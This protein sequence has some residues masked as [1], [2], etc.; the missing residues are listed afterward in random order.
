MR[1]VEKGEIESAVGFSLSGCVTRPFGGAAACGLFLLSR[2]RAPWISNWTRCLSAAC[3]WARPALFTRAPWLSAAELQTPQRSITLLAADY[4][5]VTALA[6]GIETN[7]GR[8]NASAAPGASRLK[9]TLC[10]RVFEKV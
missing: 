5:P 1:R 10:S 2:L 3:L 6:F 4:A 7:V 9:L 8:D